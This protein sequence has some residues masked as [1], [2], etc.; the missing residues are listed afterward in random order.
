MG[1][2]EVLLG[3]ADPTLASTSCPASAGATSDFMEKTTFFNNVKSS[4]FTDIFRHK[5]LHCKQAKGK[6]NAIR[7][8]CLLRSFNISFCRSC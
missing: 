1:M 6:V 4:A 2:L 5:D 3:E 7:L 8:C